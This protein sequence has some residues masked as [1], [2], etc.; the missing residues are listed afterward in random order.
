M[1]DHSADGRKVLDW[2]MELNVGCK[3]GVDVFGT[4]AGNSIVGIAI[5]DDDPPDV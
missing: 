4:G 1:K 2:G 3:A 5:F